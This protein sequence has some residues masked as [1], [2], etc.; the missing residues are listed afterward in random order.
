MQRKIIP[1][2]AFLLF[3][4]FSVEAQMYSITADGDPSDWE[5]N[6][7]AYDS[8]TSLSIHGSGV[9]SGQ[10]IYKGESGD[11]RTDGANPDSNYDITEIRVGASS[12]TLYILVRMDDITDAGLPVVSIAMAASD[13]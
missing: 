5:N 3:S 1:L 11:Q 13:N 10:W 7:G 8:A 9:F 6:D 2:L 4:F 12:T